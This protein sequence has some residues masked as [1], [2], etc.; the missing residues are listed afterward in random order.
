MQTRQ[1]P[2]EAVRGCARGRHVVLTPRLLCRSATLADARVAAATASDP[3]AQRWL[4]WEPEVRIPE[5]ERDRLLATPPDRG[6]TR[7]G[8]PRRCDPTSLLAIDPER[9]LVA[10]AVTLTPLS[11]EVCELG[12]H[13]AP[14]YRG[15]GLGAELF[16]AGLALA[17][18]HLH[19]TEVRAGAEPE[20]VA[21][22]RSLWRAGFDPVPGPPTHRLPDG[23]VI[24]SAWFADTEPNPQWCPS[25]W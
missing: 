18:R 7:F 13:L 6:R 25:L 5:D 16:T 3:E 17:H 22:V 12:G 19:F 8:L 23:R 10:G 1:G 9:D 24:P 21:S 11:H 14:A 4:G 2:R 20:N 15:R